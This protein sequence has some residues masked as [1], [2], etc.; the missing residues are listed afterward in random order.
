VTS[1]SRLPGEYTDRA[2]AAIASAQA[3]A[4]DL[5]AAALRSAERQVLD[6]KTRQ[7]AGW[8]R[9]LDLGFVLDELDRLYHEV[10]RLRALLRQHGVPPD[11]AR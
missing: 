1:A 6:E 10:D 4:R 7:V 11:P 3:H 8:A 9:E 5:S 2:A